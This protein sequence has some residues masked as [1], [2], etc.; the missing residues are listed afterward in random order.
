[1]KSGQRRGIVLIQ[2]ESASSPKISN[3]FLIDKHIS[4]NPQRY[5]NFINQTQPSL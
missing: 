1:M 5:L 2:K 3:W 4:T